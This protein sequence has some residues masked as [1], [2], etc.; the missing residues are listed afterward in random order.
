MLRDLERPVPIEEHER[1]NET[2]GDQWRL[3]RTNAVSGID[4]GVAAIFTGDV[5]IHPVVS[6]TF[7]PEKA[8]IRKELIL[9]FDIDFAT[10]VELGHA[11]G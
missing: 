3:Y 2:D 11:D 9:R 8:P 6:V 1:C 10:V 5:D 4:F 7:I